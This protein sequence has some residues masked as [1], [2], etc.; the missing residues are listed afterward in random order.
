M[1]PPD[2]RPQIAPAEPE[3]GSDASLGELHESPAYLRMLDEIDLS[4]DTP[5]ISAKA[6]RAWV[7]S[8]GTPGELPPPEPD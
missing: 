8:W 3:W 7:E 4:E 1:S 6:V 5:S 2:D